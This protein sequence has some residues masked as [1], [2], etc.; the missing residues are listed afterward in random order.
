LARRPF[1]AGWRQRVAPGQ[2]VIEVSGLT[3][4]NL[5]ALLDAIQRH[6]PVGEP[7]YPITQSSN[8]TQDFQLSELI[9]EQVYLQTEEE[10]PYRTRVQVDRLSE[11]PGPDGAK[12]LVVKAAIVTPN[13]RYQRM[14]I[15]VGA[16]KIKAVGTAA[17]RAMEAQLGRKVFLD[18]DVIVDRNFDT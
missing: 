14:L 5:P 17:R 4:H 6:L 10:V 3:G 12:L 2:E 1:A 15:G 11:R 16:R 7:L 8:A 9:R 18:L 13:D